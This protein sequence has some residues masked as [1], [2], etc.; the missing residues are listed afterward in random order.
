MLAEKFKEVFPGLETVHGKYM[1][2]SVIEAGKKAKG[3]AVTV[4]TPITTELWEKHLKGEQ[5]LGVT[6]INSQNMCRFAAI[7]IDKYDIDLAAMAR[8]L[9]DHQ[10]PVTLIRSKS[11]GPQLFMFFKEWTPCAIVREK[12]K[13][14]AS[15][16]GHGEAEIFPKQDE[17]MVMSN[18]CGSWINMPYFK[19]EATTRYALNDEGKAM[20]AEEFLQRVEQ[21]SITHDFLKTYVLKLDD[22]LNDAPPCLQIILKNGVPEGT[23]NKVMFQFAVY[24]KKKDQKNMDTLIEAANQKYFMPPLPAEEITDIAKSVRRKD[25]KFNC[26]ECPFSNHCNVGLCR[27]R[28]YGIGGGEGMP[29]VQS[30]TMLMTE[31]PIWF[32]TVSTKDGTKRMSCTTEDLQNPYRYQRR[33]METIRRAPAI[34]KRAEW[35]IVVNEMLTNA[36]EIPMPVEVTPRG[37]L[38]DYLEMFC[39]GRAQAKQE[40]EIVLGKPWTSDNFHYFRLMDFTAFLERQRFKELSLQEIASILREITGA[41]YDRKWIKGKVVRLWRVPEFAKMP[42]TFEPPKQPDANVF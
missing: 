24:A 6:P 16:L 25:Y 21:K 5:G 15:F 30:V 35:D 37:L 14:I 4:H 28:K 32:I 41:K 2:P 20:S 18:D 42:E 23:R 29:D 10:I 9:V 19:H 3:Q 26:K 39:T 11:G 38:M 13:E 1:L 40:D 8:R 7:D 12:L 33:C 27:T 31:P 17:I 36:V 22:E 34:M